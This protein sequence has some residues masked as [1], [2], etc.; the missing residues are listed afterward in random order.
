MSTAEVDT[1]PRIVGRDEELR[2]LRLKIDG[3]SSGRPCAVFVHGESGIGKTCLVRAVVDEAAR[4]GVTVLWGKCLRFDAVDSTYLPLVLA[5][6]GWL[7]EAASEQREAV[8]ADFAGASLLL[9]SLGG[10]G[11]T[12]SAQL[13]PVVDELISRIVALGP[14]V[15]INDDV[16]WASPA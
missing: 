8:L 10:A 4:S 3:A 15:L 13:M 11:S 6:E 7:D 9:P 14:T 1:A 16:Q 2:L 12:A 5:L